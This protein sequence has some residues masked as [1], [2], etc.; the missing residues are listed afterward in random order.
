MVPFV[1][2]SR[3]CPFCQ[4]LAQMFLSLSN[5]PW[6]LS[7]EPVSIT[8]KRFASHQYLHSTLFTLPAMPHSTP[9]S[10][11]C[12][13]GACLPLIAMD[14]LKGKEVDWM[15]LD[16]R[17]S[18]ILPCTYQV[19]NWYLQTPRL[20]WI[21]FKEIISDFILPIQR[22]T[23]GKSTIALTSTLYYI[24]LALSNSLRAMVDYKRGRNTLKCQ[25]P[26]GRALTVLEA[27]WGCLL[28]SFNRNSNSR[29]W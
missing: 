5:C 27:A 13:G 23:T 2:L 28:L 11:W 18:W 12:V 17:I 14:I 6:H 24:C 22:C 10:P 26:K 29:L 9:L 3:P 4:L 21:L 8:S 15:T 25:R 20:H 7:S 1:S 19:P 16:V